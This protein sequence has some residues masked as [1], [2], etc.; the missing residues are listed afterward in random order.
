VTVEFMPKIFEE[1][2]EIF[3]EVLVLIPFD[4]APFYYHVV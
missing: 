4:V 1:G 2:V 3:L